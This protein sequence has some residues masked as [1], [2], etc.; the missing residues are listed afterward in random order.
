MRKR[1]TFPGSCLMLLTGLF[2]I[3]VK[4]SRLSKLQYFTG[5]GPVHGQ[6]GVQV[7]LYSWTHSTKKYYGLIMTILFVEFSSLIASLINDAVLFHYE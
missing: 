2:V 7:S 5:K 3:I 1:F 4:P 6:G